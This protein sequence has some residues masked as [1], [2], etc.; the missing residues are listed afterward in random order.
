MNDDDVQSSTQTAA[1]AA[2]CQAGTYDMHVAGTAATLALPSVTSAGGFSGT[3]SVAQAGSFAISG[4]CT[5]GAIHFTL[6]AFGQSYSG[7]Y[8]ASGAMT[9]TMTYAGGNLTWSATLV[10]PAVANC[11][12]GTYD[13]VIANAA[14]TLTLSSVSSNGALGGTLFA[15]SAGTFPISGSCTNGSISFTQATYGQSY[16]GTYAPDGTMR[17]TLV[18]GGNSYPWSA[19][20]HAPTGGGGG[21][22]G[23]GGACPRGTAYPDGCESAPSGA[24]QFPALLSG[25]AVRAPWNVAG[26]DYPVGPLTSAFKDPNTIL[27]TIPGAS[28]DNSSHVVSIT[29]NNVVIDG[30][31][32]TMNGGWQVHVT[33][34]NDPTISNCK[35]L[36][37]ANAADPIVMLGTANAPTY[38]HGATVIHNIIDGAGINTGLGSLLFL[39]RYGAFVIQYN[40]FRRSCADTLDWGADTVAGGNQTTYDMRYNLIEDSGDLPPNSTAHPDILQTFASNNY[41]NINIAFNTFYESSKSNLATQGLTLQGNGNSPLATFSTGT[42]SNN[43]IRFN[44]PLGEINYFMAVS[45][46]QTTGGWTIQ[47]NYIDPASLTSPSTLFVRQDSNGG[48]Y[49]GAINKTANVNMVSG[50]SI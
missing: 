25:Y 16:S 31:D 27:N 12:A 49:H 28:G 30:Y 50:S 48:P 10:A 37:G 3:V 45:S 18:T 9:G 5:N 15:S 6:P 4:T 22:G 32:F 36:V 20:L 43:T 42:V 41:G 47:S 39:S 8:D 40:W 11:Q 2:N 1:T 24:A 34:G 46:S 19:S 33:T 17:G 21:G 29:G 7:T 14:V 38:G 26:V 23:G 44:G 35:F 13:A